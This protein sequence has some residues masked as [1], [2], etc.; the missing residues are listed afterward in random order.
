MNQSWK[1]ASA[2]RIGRKSRWRISFHLLLSTNCCVLFWSVFVV[3][4]SFLLFFFCF[5]VVLNRNKVILCYFTF[6]RA[7]NLVTNKWNRNRIFVLYLLS[8]ISLHLPRGREEKLTTFKGHL[9]HATHHRKSNIS[10]WRQWC[11]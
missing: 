1:S 8:E 2:R 11:F 5:F 6:W 9:S 4:I 10:S 3:W 7:L